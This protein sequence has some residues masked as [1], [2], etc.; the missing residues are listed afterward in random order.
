MSQIFVPFYKRPCKWT[1]QNL[2]GYIKQESRYSQCNL[3][4]SENLIISGPNYQTKINYGHFLIIQ[5]GYCH[6]QQPPCA[7]V[8]SPHLHRYLLLNAVVF[9]KFLLYPQWDSVQVFPT[10]QRSQWNNNCIALSSKFDIIGC[11]MI[12]DGR[13]NFYLDI[14][15]YCLRFNSLQQRPLKKI[16]IPS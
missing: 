8:L 1:H 3:K 4:K 5:L 14:G 16:I 15:T 6:K 11:V 7:I 9:E 10:K 2:Q 13:D 12:A